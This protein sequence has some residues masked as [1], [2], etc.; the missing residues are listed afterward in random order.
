[1]EG[2]GVWE[3]REEKEKTYGGELDVIGDGRPLFKV[4]EGKY[5]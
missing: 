1:M 5:V 2:G 4:E 3:C